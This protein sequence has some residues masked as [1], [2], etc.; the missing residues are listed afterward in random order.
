M[1][2]GSTTGVAYTVCGVA[3]KAVDRCYLL[4]TVHIV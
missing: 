4:Y 2:D 3:Q 1:V